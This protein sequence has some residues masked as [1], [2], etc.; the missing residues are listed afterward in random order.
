MHFHKDDMAP[1]VCPLWY[2]SSQVA[3]HAKQC[4]QVNI[5]TVYIYVLGCLT[6]HIV[7]PSFPQ[8]VLRSLPVN[9]QIVAACTL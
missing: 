3:T 1:L 7:D 9:V 6:L 5:Y 8:V 4:M 2:I